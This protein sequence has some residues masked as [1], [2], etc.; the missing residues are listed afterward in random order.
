MAYEAVLKSLQRQTEVSIR[1]RA[2]VASHLTAAGLLASF[3]AAVGPRERGSHQRRRPAPVVFHEHFRN[4]VVGLAATLLM[5]L[6][7]RNWYYGASASAILRLIEQG[8]DLDHVRRDM[9][10]RLVEAKEPNDNALQLLNRLYVAVLALVPV[11]V[12]LLI[13]GIASSR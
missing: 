5:S 11:Q 13:A 2:R 1:Y 3:G 6:P 9:V 4:F 12:G 7:T 8:L 10:D